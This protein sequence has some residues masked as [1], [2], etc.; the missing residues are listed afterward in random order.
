VKRSYEGSTTFSPIFEFL[1]S[2]QVHNMFARM[3]TP[4]F[5]SFQVV[6]N[7]VGCGEAI[8]L[9]FE[10]DLK[11]IIPLLMTCFATLNPIIEC[12]TFVSHS[13]ELENEGN[14]FGVGASFKKSSWARVVKESF[15]LR[16]LSIPLI[17]ACEDLFA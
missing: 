14:V 15:L 6:E 12:W 8:Q 4:R 5:K 17:V 3:L 7:L 16:R 10:Y 9:T 1:Y 13:D 2:N 11:A